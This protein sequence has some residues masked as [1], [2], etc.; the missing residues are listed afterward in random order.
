[1]LFLISLP[2]PAQS[3]IGAAALNGTITDPSGAAVPNA[4]IM[5]TN[6]ATGLVRATQTSDV[7]LYN[8]TGLPVGNYDLSADAPGFKTARRT[9]I[10]LQVGAVATI[11]IRL[12]VGNVQET[13]SVES[14]AP[15]VETTRTSAAANVTEKAVANLPVNGRNFIDFTLLTPGVV[16]DVRGTGDLSFA[17]QRG[18]SNSLLVDGADSNNLFFGQA[19]G[20]TGFR[21]YAFSEDAVQEF[22][23]NTS[24]YSAE[25]GRAGGGTI[26]MVTKSGTNA[27]HGTLFEF[28]RD[29]SLN[30]NTFT[31]NRS[32]VRKLPYH[33]NQF[34][35]TLGGPI[36]RD[37]LFFFFSY[38]GQRNTANQV[39]APN[40]APTGAAL[41]ALQQYLQ[42][43]LV[44]LDNNVYLGKVDW[45][46]SQN[47][48]VSVRYN[49]SRYTGVNQENPGPTSALQHTGD[50]QVNTD[51]LA[52]SYTRVIGTKM[53]WDTRFNF[54]RDNEPGLAN[55]SGP[56]VSIINGII[57]GRNNF[58]P[59]YTNTRGYQPVNSLSYA[60]GRHIFKFG[61]DINI[62]R[63]DN[64]FPGF[65]S[66]GFVFPSYA[67]F[68][69]A[70]PSTY[71][72]GFSST[73]TDAPISHPDVNEWAFYGQDTWRVTD[74][75]TLNLGLR[76]DLF[77]Y[78]QPDTLNS[79]AG[80]IAA[81][82]RTNVIP[83]DHTNVG[84]RA[85]FAY[86]PFN[87]DKT[88]LRGGYGIFYART[89]GLLLSTAILQ[90]GIDVLTYVLSS[91][92]PAYPNTLTTP[93]AGG[94]APPNINVV[95]P[96]FRTSEVEQWNFQVERKLGSNYALTIGYLGVHGLHL[97]R[98]R[99][100]N[101]FPAVLTQGTL[102]TGG[103]VQYWRHP[104]TNG[105]ARPNPA[106][107]R[108][109]LFDS[110][111][112]SSYN[113]AFIQVTK[114]FSRNFQ[115]LGSYTLS[116]AIDTAPDGTSVVTG[117]AGDD[118]KVAQ[119]TLQPSLERGSSVNDIRNRFVLSAVWDLNYANSIS[120]APLKA[121]LGGWTLSTISQLQSGQHV[122]V[123]TT[124]DPG[125]DGNN[126]NDRA[127]LFGRNTLVA[128]GLADWDL[129][130]TREV[131]LKEKVRLRLIV[132]GFDIVNHAN[133][134]TIQNN[135]YTFKSGVFTPTTNY[136]SKLT[137]QPQGVGSR[138][139]QLA[140]KFTF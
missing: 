85:G 136:L 10:P 104:G 45:N 78:R 2:L 66:G 138:V 82:L 57:F 36:K 49:A 90:N 105:P 24:G 111:A 81:N 137:M 120:S 77:A 53:V 128:P 34:G 129:R 94:L 12:E 135:I 31:N 27:F 19:T 87:D 41:A 123:G 37:K 122:N 110:G 130:L 112:D 43:Y 26:N 18:T 52:A 13:V 51:N 93:P 56:E 46:I 33:F 86:K 55:S 58:S 96:N 75:L 92:L 5:V 107:G 25:V 50:N 40:I 132:E 124:G 15:V 9:A 115:V 7:G 139:F 114:R 39:L 28:Y 100:I 21:P 8:L 11:D 76:Y 109:T 140:A 17:G 80:L 61:L 131:A 99:D 73:G 83:D 108:I 127:P 68:L 6:T 59:R 47:D 89:P 29:K 1:V 117:N 60:T 103:S 125:N 101:L 106:F 121:L 69:A 91:N 102:S 95:A 70:Q 67:T 23:V 113:G 38:D 44:G 65:F 88:V 118:A 48:R 79:N 116:K 126:F 22:Q 84:P 35:G 98:S 20:R 42:P 62:E 54:L 4:K 30:A 32:G 63:A 74:R 134:A 72:Q 3:V 119:D 71:Q 16:R 97:T 14:E 64:Y 133:F